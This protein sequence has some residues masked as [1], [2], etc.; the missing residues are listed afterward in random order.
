M[1]RMSLLLVYK[2]GKHSKCPS[3]VKMWYILTVKDYTV[4]R[5][6]YCMQHDPTWTQWECTVAKEKLHKVT[7]YMI[8]TE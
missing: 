4:T 7:G 2:N 1:F 3:A 5:T 6:K 8:I